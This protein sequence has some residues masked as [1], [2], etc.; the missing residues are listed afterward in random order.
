MMEVYSLF[1]DIGLAEFILF[2]IHVQLAEYPR[3]VGSMNQVE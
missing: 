3:I 1:T 2:H